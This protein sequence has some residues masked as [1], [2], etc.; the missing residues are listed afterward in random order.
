MEIWKTAENDKEF[1]QKRTY[2]CD[3]EHYKPNGE[4]NIYIGIK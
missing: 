4:I 1:D 2:F 3:F